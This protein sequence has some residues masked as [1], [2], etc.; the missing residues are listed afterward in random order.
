MASLIGIEMTEIIYNEYKGQ[1][2]SFPMK[3]M[4]KE[5]IDYKI[6]SEYNGSNLQSLGKKYNYSERWVRQIIKKHLR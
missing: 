6:I 2:I 5:V 1:Q 4:A 3:L